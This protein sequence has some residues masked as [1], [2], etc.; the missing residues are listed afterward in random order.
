MHNNKL[1]LFFDLKTPHELYGFVSTSNKKN[2]YNPHYLQNTKNKN[3]IPAAIKYISVP[4]QLFK[5][6]KPKPKLKQFKSYSP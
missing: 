6:E 3:P 2:K 5:L 4:E 1:M